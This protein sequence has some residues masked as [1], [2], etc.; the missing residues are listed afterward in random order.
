MSDI[1][2]SVKNL[3]VYYP[4]KVKKNVIST[5]KKV[6]KAV[7]GVSFDVITGEVFGIVGESGCGKTTTGRAI[8]QLE[9]PTSGT[10]CF[11]G[12]NIDAYSKEEAFLHKKEVQ[13]IFQDNFSSLDPKFTVGRSI[14]EPLSVHNCGNKEERRKKALKLMEDVGLSESYYNRYPHEFSGGQ[15]QRIG[16]ARALA[17]D[18]SLIVCDEPVSALDVSIQAQIL[19]LMI[20]IQKIY[21]LTLIFISHNL[22]VVK[23]ICNRI[24]VMYLGHIVELAECDQLFNEHKHPYTEALIKAIPVPNPE[25]PYTSDELEG[26][27]PSPMNPPKGCPFVTRC[28]RAYDACYQFLPEMKEISDGHFVA[29]HLYK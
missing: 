11:K 9:K 26:D 4:V 7:D 21:N 5:E 23:H 10:I 12:K 14:E 1:I 16:I 22:S 6:V 18:P 8:V 25:L 19:N 28:S 29:C 27:V 3:Q 20:D 17:L 15:R 2:L 24:A 13:M